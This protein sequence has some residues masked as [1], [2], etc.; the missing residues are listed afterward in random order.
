MLEARNS[1]MSWLRCKQPALV[2]LHCHF[3]IVALI[4]NEACKVLPEELEDLTNDMWYY[5]QKSPRRLRQFEEFPSFEECKPHK[6]LKACQTWWL[7]LEACVNHLIKQYEALLSYF[8]STED[9]QAVVRRVKIVLEKP[10]TIVNLLFLCSALPIVNNFNRY[11]QQQSPIVQVFYQELDGFTKISV[12][13]H[14]FWVR[15]CYWTCFTSVIDNSE[16][17]LPYHEV[18]VGHNT[19]S[20]LEEEDGLSLKMWENL[21]WLSKLGGLLQPRELSNDYLWVT[22]YSPISNGFNQAYNN[23][24][25]MVRCLLQQSV[26]LR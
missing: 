4:A 5:F 22:S 8:R 17:Y 23:A 24:V 18:F 1:V 7:S 16:E 12:A 2:A 9:K 3:H 20:Y 26:F 11:M 14:E 21:E 15:V 25:W 10:L 19:L 6:L 13:V